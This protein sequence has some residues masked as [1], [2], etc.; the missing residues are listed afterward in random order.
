MHV[1]NCWRESGA[2]YSLQH[3]SLALRVK[4]TFVFSR[5]KGEGSPT[6][7]LSLSVSREAKFPKKNYVKAKVWRKWNRKSGEQGGALIRALRNSRQ[8]HQQ[9]VIYSVELTARGRMI[10]VTHILLTIRSSYCF[11]VVCRLLSPSKI[12]ANP[13]FV[14]VGELHPFLSTRP[15][16]GRCCDWRFVCYRQRMTRLGEKK[17]RREVRDGRECRCLLLGGWLT[18]VSCTIQLSFI[19]IYSFYKYF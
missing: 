2:F 19:L 5:S 12:G 3:S 17:I 8:L 13:Q 16:F 6:S 18:D 9:P 10:V 7:L 14:P 4:G 11:W 1:V 15:N